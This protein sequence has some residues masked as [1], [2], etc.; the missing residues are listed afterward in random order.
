MPILIKYQ[1]ENEE[2]HTFNSSHDCEIIVNDNKFLVLVV[3]SAK[4]TLFF[5]SV[6]NESDK[7]KILE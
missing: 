7:L 6:I 5:Y 4:N 2:N 3:A 1:F